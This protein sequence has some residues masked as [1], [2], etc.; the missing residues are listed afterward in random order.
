MKFFNMDLHV[1][2][3]EDVTTQLRTLG[4]DVE[5]HLMSGHAWALQ[6]DRARCGSGDGDQGKVGYGSI[7]L[8]T[9]E[10]LFDDMPTLAL[11]DQWQRENPQLDAFDGFIATYPPAFALLYEKFRGHVILDIPVRYDLHFTR[12]PDAWRQF[13]ERLAAAQDTGKLTVVANN[14]YDAVYYTG[15]TGRHAIHISNTCDY[16]DRLAPKW[17]P[18][19]TNKLLAFGEHAG[20]R[21]A[22]RAVRNVLFVRDALPQQY[23]H[24]ELIRALGIVW[25]PYNASIMSFFEHYWLNIPMFVPSQAFLVRLWESHLALSQLTWHKSLANGSN[26]RCEV[27]PDPHTREG[28]VRWMPLYDF[29]DTEEFPHLTY[30]DSWGDLQDKIA[31][32]EFHVISKRMAEHNVVRKGRNLERWRTILSRIKA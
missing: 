3:I 22:S 5:S 9:W 20:C 19:G 6:K 10:L 24:E 16:I 7:N 14:R 15:F 8:N 30:F 27:V 2:V 32:T 17:S 28:V 21:A 4:H 25:I 12:N 31:R 23:L 1:S 29:Y 13:N 11:V 26:L 18:R